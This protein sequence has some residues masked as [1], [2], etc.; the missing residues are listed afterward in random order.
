MLYLAAVLDF[1][2]VAVTAIV[3]L[4]EQEVDRCPSWL[5]A[6]TRRKSH[7]EEVFC[8]RAVRT[9]HASAGAPRVGPRHEQGAVGRGSAVTYSRDRT[10]GDGPQA[11]PGEL[12]CRCA[13]LRGYFTRRNPTVPSGSDTYTR[14]AIAAFISSSV[15]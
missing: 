10:A 11:V 5:N 13:C 12:V 14:V 2:R 6:V 4:S 15:S 7:V 1:R 8:R 3:S 9:S